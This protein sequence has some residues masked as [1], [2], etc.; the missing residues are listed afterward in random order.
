MQKTTNSTFKFSPSQEQTIIK[1]FNCI[2]KN[3]QNKKASPK[4]GKK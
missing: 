4:A 3:A 1:A 2:I